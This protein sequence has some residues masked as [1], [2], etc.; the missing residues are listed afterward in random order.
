MVESQWNIDADARVKSRLGWL[1]A[2]PADA[3]LD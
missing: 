2:W 1:P 3:G